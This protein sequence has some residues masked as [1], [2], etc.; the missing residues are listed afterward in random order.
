MIM[1]RNLS[2]RYPGSA[3]N[4]ID[5][6][7]FNVKEGEIFGFLGPNGAGKST[8]QKIL[9][10]LL[11]GYNGEAEVSGRGI[12]K[13]KEDYYERIGV[14]F[15]FPNLYSRFTGIENLQFFQSLYRG[16]GISPEKLLKQV[17]LEK[18]A[19]LKT[20][21]YSKGMKMR[22]NFA[23][24]LINNPSLLFLDEPTS[25]LDPVN[26]KIMKDMILKQKA[27]GKTVFLTTHNMSAADELCDR[28]AF[29]VDGRISLID[30]PRNLRLSQGQRSVRVESNING[31]TVIREFPL[32]GIGENNAFINFLRSGNPETIHS[33]EASLE[34]IFIKTTGSRLL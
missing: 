1:V 19:H 8:T 28:V 24:A 22:L 14:A 26:S 21:S 29:I 9:I 17:G 3:V 15:E 20:G 30:S 2:Y 23:R 31:D 13:I 12:N 6:I 33:A 10:G 18:D 27:E 25:G 4:A 7:S 34:D 11:K 32:S 5:G 16:S